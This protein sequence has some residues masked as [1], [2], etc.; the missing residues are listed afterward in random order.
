PAYL[1][2]VL[3][4]EKSPGNRKRYVTRFSSFQLP[5]IRSGL[6]SGFPLL[7]FDKQSDDEERSSIE[8]LQPHTAAG[9][10]RSE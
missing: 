6:P 7:Q 4:I 3:V 5:G 8:M 10:R 9:M 2:A 1:I